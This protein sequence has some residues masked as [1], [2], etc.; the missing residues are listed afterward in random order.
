MCHS[1]RIVQLNCQRFCADVNDLSSMLI[2]EKVNV[3]IL[4]ELYVLK[5]RLC[6]LP[7][8]WRAYVC[9]RVPAKVVVVVWYESVETICGNECT[10]Q[11]VRG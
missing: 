9:G 3:A 4:Q 5:E 10:D 11:C 6:G 1:L 7:S 2:N 8:T